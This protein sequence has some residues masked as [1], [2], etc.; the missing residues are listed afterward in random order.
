M[1]LK[2]NNIVG[3][4]LEKD[5][6]VIKETDCTFYEV[7]GGAYRQYGLMSDRYEHYS[8]NVDPQDAN[9]WRHSAQ[10]DTEKSYGSIVDALTAWYCKIVLLD[11]RDIDSIGWVKCHSMMTKYKNLY[12]ARE[13]GRLEAA[14]KQHLARLKYSKVFTD[15]I[16]I[17]TANVKKSKPSSSKKQTKAKAKTEAN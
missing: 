13:T 14:H 15:A 4:E 6:I 10:S 11:E 17:T 12:A 16:M 7:P 3:K 8:I 9:K 5:A 2:Y 1:E